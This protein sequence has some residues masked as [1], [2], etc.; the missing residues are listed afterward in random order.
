MSAAEL[1]DDLARLGITI[2]AH[3]DRLRY[4]PRSAVTP[5]LLGRLKDHK[6]E[7]LA[8]LRAKCDKVTESTGTPSRPIPTPGNR[9]T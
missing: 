2:E 7:L 5:D 3:A 6:A 4:S 8:I 1:I 9:P